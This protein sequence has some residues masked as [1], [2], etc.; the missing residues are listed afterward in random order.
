MS[1]NA[2]LLKGHGETRIHI[3]D[4]HTRHPLHTHMT[5]KARLEAFSDG[6]FSIIITIM[7]LDLK[8]SGEDWGA[9]VDMLPSIGIYALS[10]LYVGIYWTNHHSMIHA[11][12]G[13]NG[14][15]LWANLL[16]LFMLS[17]MPFTTRWMGEVFDTVP[18]AVYGITLTLSGVSYALLNRVLV[19][20]ARCETGHVPPGLDSGYKAP[21]SVLLYCAGVGLSFLS[22]WAG[23]SIYMFIATLWL[24]PVIFNLK[25][26]F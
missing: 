13:V 21:A 14:L 6:M 5:S 8:A 26:R 15:V 3:N 12:V 23:I 22:P 9:L 19:S 1:E 11:A 20:L 18:V 4:A 10:F 25:W 16:L 24:V 2:S 7:V 17:L